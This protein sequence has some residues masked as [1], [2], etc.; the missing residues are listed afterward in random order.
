[1][2]TDLRAKALNPA[3]ADADAHAAFGE[4]VKRYQDAAFGS[5]YAIRKDR[6][7]AEDVTQA[8]F[9]TA[10]LR[11][12]D[13]REPLAFGGWL[14]AIVRTECFRSIR[15]QRVVTVPLEDIPSMP[16]TSV[17]DNLSRLELRGVLLEAI[18]TLSESDRT[19]IIIRYMSDLSYQ[20]MSDFLDIP[21][22]TVK[23]RLHEA[24]KRLRTWFTNETRGERA[25]S[26]LRDYRPSRDARLEE[27]VMNLT[28]FLD[29]VIQGDVAAVGAALKAR[30]ELRDA[31]GELKPLF[32]DSNALWAAIM[33]GRAEMVKLL[34]A[35]GAHVEPDNPVDVSPLAAAAVEG[36][37][38][39]VKILLDAGANV[40]IHAACALGDGPRAAAL[41][42]E[43]PDVA[44]ARTSDGKT[45]LHF[46][47]SVDVAGRLLAAGARAE[48]EAVDDSGLTPLQWIAA[49]GRYK[50]VCRYLIAQGAKA[51]SSDIFSA[52]SYGDVAGVKRLLDEDPLLISAR[53]TRGPGVP[54]VSIGSTPLHVASVR[55]EQEIATLLIQ[56]GA[57]V[58]GHGG[59][60]QITPLHAAAAGGHVEVTKTLVA[61]GAEVTARDGT[62]R[63]TPEE[64]ARLCGHQEL[65]DL[66]KSLTP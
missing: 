63:A 44:H 45:P 39:V 11:R 22:S 65:A 4:L 24:R 7:A 32:V 31:K 55:G 38:E 28:G 53:L 50:E 36:R 25:R 26:V 27:R 19:V 16:A 13:L 29:K 59:E 18:A 46:C 20:E 30:P 3:S 54:R 47:R 8:A 57:D 10:W 15:R 60:N 41:L 58:N 43:N 17:P 9:L 12:H 62:V 23:K 14:R 51:E 56:R 42:T 40:D 48:L 64:W 35:H 21:V 6:A 61:A 2:T 49:T 52:C 66:L 37:T 5:A 34:I 1:V 33:S